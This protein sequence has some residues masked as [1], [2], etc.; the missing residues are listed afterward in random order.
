MLC[1]AVAREEGRYG[2]RA[3]V[4]AP[5]II[6]AGLGEQFQQQ[7]FS[8]EVW[9]GQRKRV[10]LRRF[11]EAEEIAEAV[12]FLASRRSAYI[13]GQTLIVDGGLRL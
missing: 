11:G 2:I 13:T 3:N 1:R 4:V 12:A 10:P 5:G 7:L 9:E 6:N 8:P